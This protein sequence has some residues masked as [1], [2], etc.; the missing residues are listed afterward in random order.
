MLT[1]TKKSSSFDGTAVFVKKNNNRHVR[2]NEGPHDKILRY[3]EIVLLLSIKYAGGQC[4]VDQ[5]DNEKGC[6]ILLF[7]HSSIDICSH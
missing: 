4:V 7:K 5:T 6:L 3:K 2:S 1:A